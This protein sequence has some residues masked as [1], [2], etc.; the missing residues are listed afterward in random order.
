MKKRGLTA[1]IALAAALALYGYTEGATAAV[2]PPVLAIH[3]TEPPS[4]AETER[5]RAHL[6]R[7]E[8]ELRARDV[9]HL[10]T[11]QREAR[12]DHLTALREYH[13]AG[14]FPHNH[15][16][17]GERVPY[18]VD[19]HGT[20]CAMAYLI[21]RSGHDELVERVRASSNNAYI[22]DL[23]GDAELL[24]WLEEAG[25]TVDE[26]AMI[27]PAYDGGGC[28]WVPAE[29]PNEVTADYAVA[30]VLASG[31]GGLSLGM[32]LLPLA[33]GDRPRWP[34]VMG[35]AAGI[36]GVGLG[37]DRLGDPGAP[38]RLG[39]ANVGIGALSVAVGTWRLLGPS[40]GSARGEGGGTRSLSRPAL[41]ASPLIG[42]AAGA[43]PGLLLRMTF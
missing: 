30:S 39:A 32:N 1:F 7:V 40:E 3:E 25:L 42:S 28:C 16:H 43:A 4:A 36:A 6:E 31:A 18:F 15:Y 5:I 11:E 24:A 41:T 23:S 29:N 12:S 2:M 20:L 38:G 37:L 22:A 34:S 19:E 9:S 10:S 17:R 21:S 33:G 14:V 13:E 27:Q 35:I 8:A 26:A